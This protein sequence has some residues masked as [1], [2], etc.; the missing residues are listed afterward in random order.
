MIH[1]EARGRHTLLRLDHGKV[2]A[3]DLELLTALAEQLDEIMDS[4]YGA[5]VITGTGAS[6]SA[7]VDL[8]RL[9]DGGPTYLEK[10]LPAFER[11]LSLLFTLPRPLIAAINGHAIAGGCVFACACDYRLMAEGPGQIGVPE[12]R[13]GVPYPGLALETM[14]YAVGGSHLHELIYLGRTYDFREGLRLGLID[15]S[16]SPDELLER[17]LSRAEE[18]ASIPAASFSIAKRQLRQPSLDRAAQHGRET[19]PEVVRT[20][21]DPEIHATIRAY[22]EA[23]VRS[24]D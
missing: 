6:F 14:R 7:G 24:K 4:P 5:V 23:A 17:A 9:L 8:W 12:L 16:C 3:L 18:L 22:M 19:D 1:R 11:A 10:L 20:W 15:E 13:V 21:L 2:S